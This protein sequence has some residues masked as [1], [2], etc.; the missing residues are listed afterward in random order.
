[1]LP[2]LFAFIMMDTN[3]MRRWVY[4]AG[5]LCCLATLLF[6]YDRGSWL[7]LTIAL[8]L[9][10]V[11][12]ER[13]LLIVL[14]VLCLVAFLLPSIQ[15]RV[16]DLFNPVYAIKS[17]Q[18]GQ[19]MLWQV[20][21]QRFASS[22]LLGVGLGEYGGSIA[23]AHSYSAYS[24]NYYAKILGESGLIGLVLFFTMHVAIIR[25]IIQTVVKRAT[26][27]NRY[28]ALGGLIGTTAM[29]IHSFVENLFEYAPTAML[30]FM[31]VGLLLLWG[32]TL[33]PDE[34]TQVEKLR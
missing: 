4:C 10:A 3:R 12:Y 31:M 21:F 23:T 7:G 30:Y 9:V 13:R 26:G 17:S 5:S 19:L 28:L 11:M 29:L 18:G 27:K 33:D 25:E 32:R 24:D 20:A 6:T 14:A 16:M 8:V 34:Q 22:P 15:H 2:I 1:M